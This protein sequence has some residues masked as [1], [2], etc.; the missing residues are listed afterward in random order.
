MRRFMMTVTVLA[1]FGAVVAT[2]QAETPV[3]ARCPPI[4]FTIRSGLQVLTIRSSSMRWCGS[5]DTHELLKRGYSTVLYYIARR[6]NLTQ[7]Q[8]A[9]VGNVFSTSGAIT[10]SPPS[11]LLSGMMSFFEPDSGLYINNLFN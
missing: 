11:A 3:P 1:A 5:N 10:A 8:V 9:Q 4:N 7:A 2:A 6:S